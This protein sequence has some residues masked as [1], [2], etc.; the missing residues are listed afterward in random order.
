M[1]SFGIAD[2]MISVVSDLSR[3]IPAGERYQRLLESIQRHFPCDAVALL[4]LRDS[5]LHP[6][7]A[8]GLSDD[9]LGRAF[10]VDDHPRL[11]R[12]LLSREP[13][14]FAADSDLPDPYDGLIASLDT[15]LHVHD[16]MGI[17][18][19]IDDQ[20]WGVLT[21][22][23]LV[24]KA[25]DQIDPV[26]LRAFIRLAEASIKVAVL[27]QSL[28]LRV[29][30]EHEVARVLLQD[31]GRSELMG[32]SP[33]IR[34]LIDELDLVAG[35]D[36]SVL[37]G[38]ETGVG[39]ELVARHLHMR[40]ARVEAPLVYVNCAALPES[41]M[42]SELFGHTKGAFSGATSARRGKFELA[43]GGTLFLDEIGELPLAMQ[44]KL[45][46]A[47]QT[48]E[49]Q[50]LG[51][52]HTHRA[53]V[54]VIAATNR[55]LKHE[56]LA[57]RFR[58]DLYHRLSVYPVTV[59]PLRER[60]RDVLLL[61][62]HFL[63]L[64]RRKLGLGS[65]RLSR[66]ACAALMAYN[67]PGNVRELEHLMSRA[68]L[69]LSASRKSSVRVLT[70]DAELLALP[71]KR[72]VPGTSE[73]DSEVVLSVPQY[74]DNA[75]LREATDRFQVELISRVLH[76]NACNRTAAARELGVDP[77]N[78]NRLLKRLNVNVEAIKQGIATL[79]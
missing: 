58:A 59:P 14:R 71:S 41:L 77:G 33:C 52:D 51:S 23:A 20:P 65:L 67:W 69:R 18:L 34:S 61:A 74:V 43:D 73:M 56:I 2:S 19:Y 4:R 11:A 1:T 57:G 27:I 24:P 46:R 35:S 79:R 62:G 75:S 66:N 32:D 25:F 48:G 68:V 78:F 28:E 21:L 44:P 54:R 63:E 3:P 31:V 45:L 17:A 49:M 22:D 8:C 42:E 53:D 76:R 47:L 37:I 9:T 29:N 16:C 10:R 50:R 15:A 38:G 7:A 12:I 72:G 40:S 6:L 60:G 26:E 39:K 36:L 30:K 55:N 70:L 5:T 13:V 64:N